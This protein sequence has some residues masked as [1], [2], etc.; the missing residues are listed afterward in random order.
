M[1][2]DLFAAF[3]RS[4]NLSFQLAQRQAPPP[5]A[6]AEHRICATSAAAI[7]RQ[8]QLHG[9]RCYQATSTQA[10]VAQLGGDEG[11]HRQTPRRARG[12]DA[13]L[14]SSGHLAALYPKV[15]NPQADSAIS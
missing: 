8:R 7:L 11:R 4:R 10:P 2:A 12:R 1:S 3:G 9:A 5:G 6:E 15:R 13:C 14:A